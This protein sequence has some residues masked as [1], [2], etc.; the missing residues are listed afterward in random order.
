MIIAT[1]STIKWQLGAWLIKKYQ[2]T[3]YNHVLIIDGELVFQA[4]HGSVNCMHI[5]VFLSKNF[6]IDK[7][8]VAP[9]K[10][11]MSFVY[12]QLGKPYSVRAIIELTVKYFTGIKILKNDNDQKFI[13]S[14]YVGKALRL[15]WV[16]DLTSPKEIVDYLTKK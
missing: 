14:E 16:N 3:L 9:E 4:S 12:R 7:F 10:V 8:E 13:C 1:S 6:I 11:D 15:D 2:N 5:D